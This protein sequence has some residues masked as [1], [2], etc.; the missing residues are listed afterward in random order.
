MA[1]AGARGGIKERKNFF[2]EKKKQKTFGPAGCCD[3]GATTLNDINRRQSSSPRH[4][5]A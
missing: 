5:R 1:G 2:F 3:A 4:G